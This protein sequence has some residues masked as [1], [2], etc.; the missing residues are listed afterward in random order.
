MTRE[1]TARILLKI[2]L[3]FSFTYAAVA[4]YLDPVSW[5]SFAPVWL[6]TAVS[7][8]VLTFGTIAVEIALAVLILF[9]RRPFYPA[10]GAAIMLTGIVVF[11]IGAMDIVFRDVS[12]A[13][14]ALALATLSK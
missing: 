12:L 3:A 11:N 8:E 2:A 13:L 10:L 9:M 6:A 5:N 4:G 7:G 1:N 14:A